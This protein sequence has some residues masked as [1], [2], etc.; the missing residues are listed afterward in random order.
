MHEMEEGE[1]ERDCYERFGN[2]CRLQPYLKLGALLTQNLR[3]GSKGLSEL[4]RIEAVNA[5]EERKTLARRQGEEAGTKL[6][7]PMFLM[8]AVVL[9]IVIVPALLSV[10]I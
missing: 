6:L 3:K 2:R 8:L 4:L 1:G 9:V 7:V 10:Q 5:F